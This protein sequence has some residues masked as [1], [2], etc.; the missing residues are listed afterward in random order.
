M[1]RFAQMKAV[2]ETLKSQ[3]FTTEIAATLA[4]TSKPDYTERVKDIGGTK[5]AHYII[6]AYGLTRADG[7][8]VTVCFKCPGQNDSYGFFRFDEWYGFK[9]PLFAG[10]AERVSRARYRLLFPPE[11]KVV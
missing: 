1:T 4:L 11:E 9:N 7:G 10:A 5:G 2:A 8:Y 3:L 6:K